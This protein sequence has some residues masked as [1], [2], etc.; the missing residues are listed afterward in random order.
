MSSGPEDFCLATLHLTGGFWAAW[1]WLCCP[2]S[3]TACPP[4]AHALI[5]ASTVSSA[6]SFSNPCSGLVHTVGAQ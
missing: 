5:I 3:S 6:L 4:D 1:A 2:D